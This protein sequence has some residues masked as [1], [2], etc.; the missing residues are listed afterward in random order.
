[1]GKLRKAVY[2]T[3]ATGASLAL[4]S[5]MFMAGRHDY[6]V[7]KQRIEEE[8]R[9]ALERS[10]LYSELISLATGGDGILSFEEQADAW[11][12]M[13]YQGPFIESLGSKAFPNPTTDDLRIG[14]ES[15][16]V[17]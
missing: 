10:S 11:N 16:K 14:V 6:E 5:G 15:Y 7:T 9:L 3:V 17:K 4:S 1:M 8:N 13:G 2:T 12:R